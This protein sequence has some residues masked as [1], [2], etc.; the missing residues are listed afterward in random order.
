MKNNCDI[1]KLDRQ[2]ETDSFCSNEFCDFRQIIPFWVHSAPASKH[3][4]LFVCVFLKNYI[5]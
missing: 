2:Q 1:V 3:Y 5:T 4:L